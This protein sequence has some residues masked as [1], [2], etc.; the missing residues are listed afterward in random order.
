MTNDI[1]VNLKNLPAEWRDEAERL[2]EAT[3]GAHAPLM[4][5][6]KTKFVVG[7]SE[8]PLGRKFVAYCGDWVRGWVKFVDDAIVDKRIGR[9]VDGFHPPERNELDS[10]D[11]SEWETGI[12]GK[13]KDPWVAQNYLPIEDVESGERYVFV[14]GSVG[15]KIAIEILCQRYARSIQRGLPTVRLATGT[16]P[17]KRYGPTPRPDFPVISWENDAGGNVGGIGGGGNN[18]GGKMVDVTPS[19]SD[20]REEPAEYTD[21]DFR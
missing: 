5:F 16:F 9:V 14:T 8:I 7:E 3:S 21:D 1:K 19:S 11:Q 20:P 18:G 4:K 15:G 2:L 12:D 17:T 13:L 6:T 10:Q